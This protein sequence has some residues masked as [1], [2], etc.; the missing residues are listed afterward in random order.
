MSPNTKPPWTRLYVPTGL[1]FVLLLAVFLLPVSL[2]WQQ[3]IGCGMV[4]AWF[5]VFVRWLSIHG[6][7]VVREERERRRRTGTASQ[8]DV[9]LSP[10]QAH[11]LR[12]MERSTRKHQCGKPE[13]L[14][15]QTML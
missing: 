5:G 9:P 3:V 12:V 8:R 6:A 2:G 1:W 7:A 14:V 13:T 4:F 11:Y 10:V 15:H